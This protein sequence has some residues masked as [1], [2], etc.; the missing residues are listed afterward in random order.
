MASDGYLYA[1]GSFSSAGGRAVCNLACWDGR[2]WSVPGRGLDNLVTSLAV[3]S[4]DDLYAGGLF[5]TAGGTAS[6]Q[7]GRLFLSE[8]P[9]F[10]HFYLYPSFLAKVQPVCF[11]RRECHLRTAL[12]VG[13]CSTPRTRELATS[14]VW[15]AMSSADWRGEGDAFVLI[16]GRNVSG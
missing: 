12:R 11:S 3:R 13:Q 7:I 15:C 16:L 10:S 4:Q 5:L 9:H 6:L 14:T 8:I 1:G 2:R